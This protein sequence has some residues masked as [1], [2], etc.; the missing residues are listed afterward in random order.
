[1]R[2]RIE[3]GDRSRRRAMLIG[4]G[5]FAQPITKLRGPANDV[6]I[7][8]KAL[9]DYCGFVTEDIKVLADSEAT[10]AGVL[11]EFQKLASNSGP[12]DVVVVYFAGHGVQNE[13]GGYWVTYDYDTTSSDSDNA[14]KA[15]ELHECI[16]AIP[17]SKTIVILD[18]GAHNQYIELVRSDPAYVVFVG[19]SPGEM[20]REFAI[21][22]GSATTY[23]GVFTYALVQALAQSESTG[24]IP[25]LI[26]HRIIDEL[27]RL[28]IEANDPHESQQNPTVMSAP[29][30]TQTPLVLGDLDEAL[31]RSL[32]DYP[33]LFR[34]SR[35][36]FMENTVPRPTSRPGSG[37]PGTQPGAGRHSRAGG[38]ASI[39]PRCGRNGP[40]PRLR[41]RADGT[42]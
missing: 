7:L 18:T 8:Q 37:L 39:L 16:R 10:R 42:R 5:S 15:I 27:H 40:D 30:S 1:M 19:C 2:A 22:T 6:Q 23:H 14:L 24:F 13:S 17:S 32:P 12:E 31:F 35:R 29:R 33:G 3:R 36:R 26:K 25:R 21:S 41:I 34:F 20:T 9:V 4:I 28:G 11:A 38:C